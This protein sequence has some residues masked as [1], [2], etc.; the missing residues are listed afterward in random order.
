R[1]EVHSAA[2][3]CDML[4]LTHHFIYIFEFKINAT[5]Q[6]ALSQIYERGY[7][8]PFLADNRTKFIIGANFS[9]QER[10]LSGWVIESV[11]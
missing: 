3:R 8:K 4:I 2:G 9:T 1:T 11:K 7:L 5:P 10:N 6:E